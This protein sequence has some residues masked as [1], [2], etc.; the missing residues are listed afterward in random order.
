MHSNRHARC[1]F[2]L[3][4]ALLLLGSILL[5]QCKVYTINKSDLESKLRPRGNEVRGLSLNTI[6][7]KQYKNGIDTLIVADESGNVIKA[8]RF[9][10][11]SKIRV[12]TKKN[13]SIKYYVKSLYIYKGEYLIGERPAPKLYGPNYFPV[14]LSEISRIEVTGI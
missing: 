1:S 6:Y 7:K 4:S 3:R 13:K 8:R 14:K 12:I 10:Y 5:V 2:I 9:G 11:D